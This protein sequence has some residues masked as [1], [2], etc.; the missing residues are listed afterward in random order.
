MTAA[1]PGGWDICPGCG[2]RLGLPERDRF[3]EDGNPVTTPAWHAECA[4]AHM[5]R[6]FEGAGDASVYMYDRP[7]PG[8]L[9]D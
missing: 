4:Q 1:R 6:R 9:A 8:A 2:E 3:D 7:H 5:R